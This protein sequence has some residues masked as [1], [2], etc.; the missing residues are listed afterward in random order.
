MQIVLLFLLQIKFPKLF[1]VLA[2]QRRMHYLMKYHVA[3]FLSAF[4]WNSLLIHFMIWP[5][6]ELFWFQTC[7]LNLFAIHHELPVHLILQYM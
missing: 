4:S 6:V 3:V 7:Q 1:P 5:F 2:F